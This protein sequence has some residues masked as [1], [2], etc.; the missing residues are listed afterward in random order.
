MRLFIA[1]KP[2]LGQAIADALP[3]TAQ[4]EENTIIKGDNV[5]V[6]CFG[7]L[8]GLK[9]PGAIDP[10]Y[11]AWSMDMLPI[12]FEPWPKEVI[13]DAKAN[14]RYMSKADRVAQIGRLIQDADCVV[15]AGDIDDEGSLLINEL[16]E[17]FHYKGPALRLD[18]SDTSKAG[19][20]QALKSMQ[21][22][23]V[24]I[25]GTRVAHARELADIVFGINPTRY[26]TLLYNANPPL[27][28]GRV[29][30]PILGLVVERDRL[31]EA[32]QTT[33]YYELEAFIATEK[34]KAKVRFIPSQDN[35]DMTDGRF[36]QPDYL[37]RIQGQLDGA[38][39]PY[40]VEKHKE[41]K[42][43]P[44]PFN[45]TELTVF[46]ERR[47]G[48]SP[49]KVMAVTQSLRENHR[50][51]TYNRSDCQYLSENHWKEAPG[52]IV[53]IAQNLN[54]DASVYDT[55]LHSAAFNDKNLTAHF[56]II[57]T[58]E[59]VDVSRMTADEKKLY[60]AIASYY[61]VQFLPPALY[62]QVVL[63]V[64]L[65]T[66][67]K[68]RG[69]ASVLLSPGYLSQLQTSSENSEG[70]S[71]ENDEVI[72]QLDAGNRQGRMSDFQIME[73]TT[74]PPA[75]Y[76]AASLYKDTTC[77]AKYVKD[78]EIRKIL[79]EKDR[80]KKGENGSIGTPATR[81]QIIE[82]LKL[83]GYLAEKEHGKKTYLISTSKGRAF[84][85]IL[86]AEIKKVDTTAHWWVI[87]EKIRAGQ[88]APEDLAHDVLQKIQDY[89]LSQKKVAAQGVP[90]S[91]LPKVCKCPK[92]GGDVLETATAYACRSRCG[93]AIY[94]KFFT[95]I[96]KKPSAE[97]IQKLF[98][99][100][101]VPLKGCSS[102]TGKK[103]DCV[104]KADWST[105]RVEL[106]L[107]FSKEIVGKCPIC[108]ADMVETAKAFSCQNQNCRAA[109]WK[110]MRFFS[111]TVSITPQMAKDLLAG[112]SIS[113]SRKK[114]GKTRKNHA[115]LGLYSKDGKT[116]LTLS[117]VQGR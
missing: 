26:F 116:Y 88:A 31:I 10:A 46:A 12:Y 77:I 80:D 111:D 85:D 66:G 105:D 44:L 1:E 112:K 55:T 83:S 21:D 15:N 89:V 19:M 28:F 49:D 93:V 78:P 107:D 8:L 68:F 9:M 23:A 87:M 84:Y 42:N 64:P 37:K 71:E 33:K 54:I 106:K 109:L 90:L 13:T 22:N 79:I 70:T 96:G 117:A 29:Q 72:A 14:T 27:T 81:P 40:T 91:A 6:W 51:I 59:H 39:L 4:Y 34:G 94:K 48:F 98:S 75:R 32:H 35:P 92:C 65:D 102:K 20:Q 113:F 36:L 41:K 17:W 62:E 99:K 11:K 63:T 53:A 67:E 69:T 61:L 3:G 108:G 16:L 110:E 43:P 76:T 24:S 74:K 100:G 104:L 5:I 30:T 2:Q 25:P 58:K 45:L 82:R 97:I 38:V 50:A 114:D 18:T 73:K 95:A 7:H 86:P 57:P 52:T 47:F 101:E 56:A 115:K 60:E 103:Y